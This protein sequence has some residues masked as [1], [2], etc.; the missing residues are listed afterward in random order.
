MQRGLLV[1]G[2]RILRATHALRFSAE[3]GARVATT[4]ALTSL[5]VTLVGALDGLDEGGALPRATTPRDAYRHAA[6][7]LTGERAPESLAS[8]LDEIVNAANTATHLM[9]A[10]T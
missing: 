2:L 7:D 4:P 9:S 3:R 5:R 1:S 8:N 10:G 6:S